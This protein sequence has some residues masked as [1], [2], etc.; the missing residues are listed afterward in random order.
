MRSKDLQRHYWDWLSTAE[1]LQRSLAEQT[2]ALTLRDITRVESIQPD[3]DRMLERLQ[4]IDQQAAASTRE[5]AASLG[6]EPALRSIM[7]ALTQAEARQVDTLSQR[8]K[9]VGENVRTRFAMNRKL[10]ESELDY[11]AG[12]MAIVS[13]VAKE[14]QGQFAVVAAGP[15]LMNQVA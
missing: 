5:L 6:V 9:I 3:L 2:A 13:Q 15:V 4:T 8:I 7:E 14:S 1:R 10:I 11:V 12:T